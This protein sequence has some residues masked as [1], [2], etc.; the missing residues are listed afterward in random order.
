MRW[1]LIVAMLVIASGCLTTT[2]K[3]ATTVDLMKESLKQADADATSRRSAPPPEVTAS[4][5]P[6]MNIQLGGGRADIRQRR[7]DVNVNGLPARDFFMGLVDGTSYNMVVH[8]QVGGEIS[9]VL[10]NVTIPEVMA[11]MRD[12]YGY[13]YDQTASGFYVLPVRM[14]TRMFQVNYLNM[15]RSGNTE[16]T[17]SGGQIAGESSSSDSGSLSGSGSSPNSV[18]SSK[19]VTRSDANFWAELRTALDTLIPAE[20]GRSVVISPQTGV[21]I[22]RAM[23]N[24]LREV[25]SFLRTTQS[26]LQRQVILEAK[27]MEVILNDGF[28][29][30]INWSKVASLGDGKSITFGQTGTDISRGDGLGVDGGVFSIA[31]DAGSFTAFIQLLE[32]QGNV[33]ILSSPRVATLNNQKAVI[34]VGQDEYFITDVSTTATT[35]DNPLVSP[36]VTLTP[37]FSGIALD[38]TPQID[39]RGGVTLHVHPSISDVQDQNKTF[40]INGQLQS[41]PTAQSTVRESDSIVYAVSGQIVVIGGLMQETATEDIQAPPVLGDIPFLGAAFRQTKQQ[42][43]KSELVILLKPLV[44]DGPG[45]WSG[46]IAQSERA[47]DRLDRGF[48]Y[49]GKSEVFGS[50]AEKQ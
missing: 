26:T 16:M 3:Q 10:K 31:I 8:P 25:E 46:P 49:G 29:S 43:R 13:E 50:K 24:E 41:L 40:S 14:Q 38:V 44:V 27:I 4:L 32:T 17:V 28:Q 36:N 1:L 15:Q 48:H 9:L 34:K 23:P 5:M 30:G 20:G 35:G 39:N 21:V 45:A 7:F 19:V 37:F 42:S 12:V 2:A 6:A 33:Q 11:V 18:P 47:L 22:V